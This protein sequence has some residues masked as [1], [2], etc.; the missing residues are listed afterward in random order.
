MFDIEEAINTVEV[1]K[2]LAATEAFFRNTRVSYINGDIESIFPVWYKEDH[3]VQ[4]RT[5]TSETYRP[6]RSS[7]MEFERTNPTLL[8]ASTNRQKN[9]VLLRIA[10]YD[11]AQFFGRM[12]QSRS[13]ELGLTIPFTYDNRSDFVS[14]NRLVEQSQYHLLFRQFGN[15]S[16]V[17]KR[18]NEGLHTASIRVQFEDIRSALKGYVP[19]LV[20]RIPK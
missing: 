13:N 16:Y 5:I 18:V 15:I 4:P 11:S 17:S 8:N 1:F 20:A 2:G 7:I 3:K 19:T 10:T 14:D 12:L 6:L 9:T